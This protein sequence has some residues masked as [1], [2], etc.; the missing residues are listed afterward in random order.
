MLGYNFTTYV[1]TI[2]TV[3][4]TSNLNFPQACRV[5]NPQMAARQVVN[6]RARSADRSRGIR[7]M[8][9]ILRGS[10]HHLHVSCYSSLV[11][12]SYRSWD[13]KSWA[14]YRFCIYV[15]R[16]HVF[17]FAPNTFQTIRVGSKASGSVA[18]RNVYLRNS[19]EG[20]NRISYVREYVVRSAFVD[21]YLRI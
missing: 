3:H 16:R 5:G 20:K 4:V 17:D 15:Q 12:A 14:K 2:S 21:S 11:V 18:H 6:F 10:W 9:N 19:A 1:L 13:S 7:S 8:R